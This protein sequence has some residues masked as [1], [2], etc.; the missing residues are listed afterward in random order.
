MLELGHGVGGGVLADEADEVLLAGAFGNFI[1]PDRARCVGLLPG[2]P[3][4]NV[5]FVG[6]AAGTGARMM[7]LDRRLRDTVEEIS[8][9][10]EHIELSGRSDFQ[11]LFADAMMFPC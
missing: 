2:V 4:E 3:I 9:G 10:V 1:R 8:L 11:H 5:R 7:L 6:N